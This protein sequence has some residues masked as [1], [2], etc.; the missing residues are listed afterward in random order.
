M[1][2]VVGYKLIDAKNEIIQQWGGTWGQ[3][4]GIPNP[5]MLPTG[6]HVHAPSLNTDYEG[7]TLVQWL[8]DEPLPQVP[9]SITRRQASLQL[10][11]IDF[12]TSQE[13]LD[14]TKTGAVPAVISAIFDAQVESGDMTP[15][16]RVL[17]EIDFAASNYYRDNQ[18]LPLMGMT[19]EQIDQFFIAASAL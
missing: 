10:L 19:D 3:C 1:Q 5:I 9:V 17:A 2:M 12:I 8:M 7:Y 11:A 15:D 13:A 14:M 6:S 18:L 16:Q 4:P